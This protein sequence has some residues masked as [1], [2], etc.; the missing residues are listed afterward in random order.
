MIYVSI[1]FSL[2][3]TGITFYKD[4]E[5]HFMS[6]INFDK[7]SKKT[8]EIID[9]LSESSNFSYHSYY[10]SPVTSPNLREDGLYGWEREHVENC[11]YYGEDLCQKISR[12]LLELYGGYEKESVSCI[13]ENYSY[14]S[15]SSTLIQMVENTF[16]LKR[17]LI[18]RVCNL[19]HFYI[20]PAPKVKAFVGKGSFDKYDMLRSFIDNGKVNA[21]HKCISE[22]ENQFIK[23]RIKKGKEFNEVLCPVQD[24]IDS[25][26]MLEYF[27]KQENINN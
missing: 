4:G 15:Q 18:E 27:L 8:K 21:F 13:I 24:I 7:S 3:S 26:W 23:K 25:Y 2:N 20:I 1:D 16:S 22:N 17:S 9:K 12:T 11:I 10:R 6:Y 14:S 19:E 5:Y